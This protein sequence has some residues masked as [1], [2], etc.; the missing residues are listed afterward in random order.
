[1]QPRVAAH[2]AARNR[3]APYAS[4]GVKGDPETEK[5]PK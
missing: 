1:M 5:R 4:R 2:A 3:E